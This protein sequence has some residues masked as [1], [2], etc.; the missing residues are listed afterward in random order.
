[1][2]IE[3]DERDRPIALRKYLPGCDRGEESSRQSFAILL[4]EFKVKEYRGCLRHG[5]DTRD[6]VYEVYLTYEYPGG[7]DI[8]NIVMTCA[9]GCAIATLVIAIQAG[10]TSASMATAAYI[11][12]VTGCVKGQVGSSFSCNIKVEDKGSTDWSGH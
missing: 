5:I 8:E 7:E 1:M 3:Q 4:D 9:R 12:C 2:N 10:G 6:H 11:A